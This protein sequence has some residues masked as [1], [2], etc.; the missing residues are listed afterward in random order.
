M[1]F[2]RLVCSLM[3]A[4][5]PI[6]ESA[7]DDGMPGCEAL[8]CDGEVVHTTTN[9][10]KAANVMRVA[11]GVLYWSADDGVYRFAPGDAAETRIASGTA[12]DAPP[13][14][15]GA[16]V[17]VIRDDG[18]YAVPAVGGT[19]TLLFAQS[20]VVSLEH[21]DGYLF[22]GIDEVLIQAKIASGLLYPEQLVG[23]VPDH[24]AIGKGYVYVHSVLGQSRYDYS[25]GDLV[26][27]GGGEAFVQRP[28]VAN[29]SG[30]FWP[31]GRQILFR[32]HD[33]EEA[34]KV[35]EL[36]AG[37]SIYAIHAD[38]GGVVWA[39]DLEEVY[40]YDLA[41]EA[42]MRVTESK[43]GSSYVAITSDAGAFYLMTFAG[44]IVSVPRVGID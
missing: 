17:Y 15:V 43:Y 23:G 2:P 31:Q 39:N 34:V 41:S 32:P 25:A 10:L 1:R 44:E 12:F 22:W 30:A 42:T 26:G 21:D 29:E 38:A 11:D 9:I 3:M 36:D 19:Q 8:P 33:G 5:A 28:L 14:I 37:R 27:F 13:V 24:L 7:D 40:R 20:Y 16:T 4:C 35:V 6:E 18:I